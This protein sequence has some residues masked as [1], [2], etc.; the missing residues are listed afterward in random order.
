M[1]LLIVGL[2]HKTAPVKIREKLHFASNRLAEPLSELKSYGE[3]AENLILSTCNRVELYTRVDHVKMG[4]QLVKQF[5]S[6]FHGISLQDF[7]PHLYEYSDD[8]AACH[9]FRVCSSLDSMVVGEPQIIGQVK[10]AYTLAKGFGSVGP[11]LSQLFERAFHVAKKVRAETRIG[12]N[13]VSVSY[14]AVELAKKIFGELADKSAMLIGAGEM[15]E[16]AARHLVGNGVKTVFVSNRTY[17]R[18]LELAQELGGTAVNFEQMPK[19]LA[20]ADIV[21]S[22]TDAPHYIIKKDQ[23]LNLIK[24]RKNKPI[25]FID[26]A[27][28][29]DIEPSVNEIENVFLYNIDD[30]ENVIEANLKERQREALKAEEIIKTEVAKFMR[31]LDTLN[32]APLITSLREKIETIRRI[33]LDKVFSKMDNFSDEEKKAIEMLTS[34]IVNKI[35]HQPI[36]SLKKHVNSTGSGEYLKVARDLFDLKQ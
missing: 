30:L 32:I 31:W 23:V 22:S 18:A 14:A 21:I 8:E 28:P 11:I 9:T 13:A 6:G 33:E 1:H 29:R 15:S 35:L 4:S 2:N 3:L 7:E 10:E 24:T 19:H 12:E 20:M 16:L 25:F 5:L 34:S 36:V 26:I 27:V 17:S